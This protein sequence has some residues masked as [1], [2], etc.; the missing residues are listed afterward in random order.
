MRIH[1]LKKYHDKQDKTSVRQTAL[2]N[3]LPDIVMEV[4]MNNVYTWA[5]EAGIEFFGKNVIGKEAAYYFEGEQDTYN[6]VNVLF[7]GA[8]DKCYVESWQ[9]RKD[10]QKRLLAWNCIAM[11]DQGGEFVGILSTAKDITEWHISEENLKT[12]EEKFRIITSSTPDHI[13]VQD[14]ELKYT[15]VVNPQLGLT[16]KDMIGKTDYDLISRDDAEKLMEIKR[17]VLHS[18][19]PYYLETSLQN[20]ANETEYFSGSFIPLFDRNN[21]MNGLIGYFRNV[22][23]EKQV[24]LSLKFSEERFRLLTYLLPV[25]V[26][27]TDCSG[28]C[29][30]TNK[31][32]NEMAGMEEGKAMG[33]E[34]VNALHPDDRERVV[35]TWNQMIET[36]E[37]WDQEYRFITA[38]GMISWMHSLAIPHRNLNGGIINYI[39]VNID[40]TEEKTAVSALKE[41]EKKYK[42]LL[43]QFPDSIVVHDGTKILYVNQAAVSNMGVNSVDELLG[44]NAIDFVHPDYREMVMKRMQD[45]FMKKETGGLAH[46]KFISNEGKVIDVETIGIPIIYDGT[47]AIQLII[48]NISE[49]LRMEEARREMEK[50]YESLFEHANDAIFLMN[51][52]VFLD[53][54]TTTLA[55]FGCDKD[56][57][58][59]LSPLQFSPELQPDGT[60]SALKAAEKIKAAMQGQVQHFEWK[61]CRADGTPFDAE[62]M[63]NHIV[64]GGKKYL[65]ASVRDISQRKIAEE[66]INAQLEELQRWQIV[67]IG[68]EDRIRQMK[69]EVNELLARLG[70]PVKYKSQE[71]EIADEN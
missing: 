67:T 69:K 10:G 27:L 44:R 22:T 31:K 66:K 46:E 70:E 5:N 24:E 30:Y 35:S 61:H 57:I 71:K 15:L 20:K 28:C 41:S 47:P 50:K 1:F 2:L 29:I 26:Y 68:R 38:E 48:R 18:K 16:E 39:G 4:D 59:G 6:K 8:V 53:C 40:I 34:W 17:E 23:K 25:G 14:M 55:M 63:L 64:I 36:G 33:N 13:I 51:E 43:D 7:E 54:N 37:D 42:T 49:R 19:K 65:Q 62:I 21:L 32:W 9:R 11:K 56:Q 52:K 45:I 3:I 58:I 12:S 60:P